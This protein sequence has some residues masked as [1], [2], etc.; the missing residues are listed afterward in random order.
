MIAGSERRIAAPLHQAAT[1]RT[2]VHTAAA[3]FCTRSAGLDGRIGSSTQLIPV[4]QQPTRDR[5][6]HSDHSSTNNDKR[7]HQLLSVSVANG[8]SLMPMQAHK[9]SKWCHGPST[10]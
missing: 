5:S 6:I 1:I 4:P 10:V 8:I 3:M 9:I 2:T 7:R